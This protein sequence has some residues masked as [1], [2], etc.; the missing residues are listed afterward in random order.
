MT[1]KPSPAQASLADR[2]EL[3]DGS[4]YLSGIQALVRLVIDQK[5]A[6]ARAGLKTGAFITGYPGSPL[7]G[8]EGA[9]GQAK[10]LL[11]RMG[12]IHKPAQN[13]ELGA[14]TLM[15]TQMID[16]HPSAGYDGV[17][18][19]WYGKGPGI[20]R[21]GDAIKHGNFAGTSRNGAVVI[22]SG[23]DHE[24]KSS[25]VPYQQDF[26]F[27]H[28]GVPILYPAT[29]AEFLEMGRHAVALSR[30]SGCWVALKLAGALCDGGQS[31]TVRADAD[32]IRLPEIAFHG[33]P[34]QKKANFKFF[35]GRNIDT[36]RQLYHER[37]EAARAYGQANGLNRITVESADDRLGLV[38]AGKSYTDLRQSLADLGFDDA[39]LNA[40]GIRILK[41]GLLTPLDADIVARFAQGLER[42]IVVE[43]KRDFLE[44]QV[45]AAL[46]RLGLPARLSGKHDEAGLVQFP[47]HGGFDADAISQ[48]LA[49]R[50]AALGIA[51]PSK[52]SARL[53]ELQAV[54]SRAYPMLLK[55][56]PNFCSGCPHNVSIRLAPGQQAWAAPG[57]HIFA[58]MMSD[59][60]RRV[61]AVTQF[62]GEGLP[63]IGLSP[64]TAR[65][66]IV[67][68]VGDGSLF[69][70]SYLNIRYAIAQG[71]SM[72]FKILFN[73]AIA[74]TG[75]QPPVSA[76]TIPELAGL[77]AIEGAV[78]IA[79]VTREPGLYRDAA[80]PAGVELRDADDLVELLQ[81]F[82]QTKGVTIA[83][84]DGMCANERRRQQKRG[85]RPPTT[86]FTLVNEEV[87][88]NC[89][90]CGELANCMSLQK[91]ETALGRKTFIHQSSCNQDQ[92]CV[93]AD[94]PS[95]LTVETEPGKGLRKPLPPVL[96][97][98]LPSPPVL[99]LDRPYFVYIPG[100][101]GTGVVTINAILSQAAMLDGLSVIS[102][103]QM[104][105]TQKWGPVLSSLVLS[106]QPLAASN[107]VGLG[108]AD[109]YLAL[110]PVAASDALNLDRCT[111]GKTIAVVNTDILPTADMVRD[112][113]LHVPAKEMLAAI[114]SVTDP[115]RNRHL[116]A[117]RIAEALLGDYMMTNMVA[118]GAACQAGFLPIT[119]ASIEAAIRINGVQV[120]A[121][122]AAL[123]AGR[124]SQADPQRLAQLVPSAA[125]TLA[126]RF[127][128]LAQTRTP[129]RQ[130]ARER[131][132][133]RL[134]LA[135][136]E[137]RELFV[138]L[139]E[140]LIDY[141]NESYAL[142]FADRIVAVMA[143]ERRALGGA[144]DGRLVRASMRGLHKLMTYKDEY[145]VARLMTQT[146]FQERMRAGF[147]PGSRFFYRFQPHILRR[148]G[149]KKK[150]AL[151]QG[152]TPLLK[153]L[154]GLRG[155]RG[156]RGGALDP[157]G[158]NPARQ[159]ERRLIGWYEGLLEV[160]M[161]RLSSANVEKVL[162]LLN[163]PDS[164]RGY[165][166]I[167]LASAQAARA[168]ATA[169]LAEIG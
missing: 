106:R 38:A 163:L 32:P 151:G 29:V 128:H 93:K 45:G 138:K 20:D 155:L 152:F 142:R 91:V 122:L 98:A 107:K 134:E 95:F 145:E 109:L 99:A 115:V 40:A 168:K 112:V 8:I 44:R 89:G 6:D 96:D 130:A 129:A 41:I 116:D 34:F 46:A 101:G 49:R 39:A 77:L 63:W 21:S 17:V 28:M 51:L 149:L 64:Y 65:Q 26:M 162:A 158:R 47:Q 24:A 146:G 55:R 52:A 92:S 119:P 67:Q 143:Q 83:I 136:G 113:H 62:G 165:E 42:I 125:P 105:A 61:E 166:G 147:E 139:A 154:A 167:K 48:I 80:L 73:G 135:D 140:D 57:C 70:A 36:E 2:Y 159:E 148:L 58:I 126:D 3:E 18:G 12:I 50:F 153:M 30:Y 132:G 90:Q 69:H 9:L 94:C 59:P 123:R 71:V 103:D 160:A 75:G 86:Q 137:T 54:R 66:H 79:I 60:Q 68:N 144:S 84:L 74:N 78:R 7:G 56:T 124:L 141:Q 97:V 81:D 114:N 104:G 43:E 133:G 22:L 4:V 164:I 72:T 100:V 10:P 85:K 150:L 131:L 1:S 157:F 161:S 33:Q 88:E 15:G 120:E 111:P 76:R 27:E 19:Y 37:L 169:L 35:P 25:T 14:T 23:E 117:R 118:V 16:E 102:F 108:K 87:C 110:D 5:R 127:A 11:D 31:V 53:T 121:N 13:E 156:L 82:E